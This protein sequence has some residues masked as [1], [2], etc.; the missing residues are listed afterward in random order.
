[1]TDVSGSPGSRC[2]RTTQAESDVDPL[3]CGA[4]E[5]RAFARVAADLRAAGRGPTARAFDA[6][7]AAVAVANGLP[8]VTLNRR[9]FTGIGGLVVHEVPR[10]SAG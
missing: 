8:L 5:A 2:G 3:P 6:L 9:D 4:A 10:P 1:V 7:I